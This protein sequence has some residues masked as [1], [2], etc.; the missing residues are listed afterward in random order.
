LLIQLN[1]Q[2]HFEQIIEMW[3]VEKRCSKGQL[4]MVCF[5]LTAWVFIWI[6]YSRGVDPGFDVSDFQ[7]DKFWSMSNTLTLW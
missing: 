4:L 3:V 5:R 6:F 7:T 1:E 2:I